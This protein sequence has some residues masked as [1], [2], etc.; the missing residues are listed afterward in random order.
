MTQLVKALVTKLDGKNLILGTGGE[1]QEQIP[2]SCLKMSTQASW[3]TGTHADI[4][5]TREHTCIHTHAH[6]YK[7]FIIILKTI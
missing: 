4:T 1:R 3:P 2:E 7:I 6:T 5:Y